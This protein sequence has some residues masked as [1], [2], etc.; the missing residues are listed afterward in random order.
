MSF[1]WYDYL[2]LAKSLQNFQNTG[3]IGEAF[4]RA[5]IS[6]AY[7]AVY[8][9]SSNYLCNI[10]EDNDLK[11][12]TKF[13]DEYARNHILDTYKSFHSYVIKQF[14]NSD[15]IL[16]TEDIKEKKSEIAEALKG[17]KRRRTKADYREHIGN[18]ESETEASIISADLIIENL[19]FLRDK[20]ISV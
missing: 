19:K 16:E 13:H 9:L 12:A 1:N 11:F 5:S 18:V 4:Y 17:L 8:G 10:E 15:D 6:R 3:D 20:K 7:Y 14:E 2:V